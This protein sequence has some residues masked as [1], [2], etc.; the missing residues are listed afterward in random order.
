MGRAPKQDHIVLETCSP[1]LLLHLQNATMYTP[2]DQTAEHSSDSTSRRSDAIEY[3]AGQVHCLYLFWLN[4][5]MAM[6]S[7]QGQVSGFT[8]DGFSSVTR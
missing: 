5:L 4:L 3:I 8:L 7:L 2:S 1:T 6:L